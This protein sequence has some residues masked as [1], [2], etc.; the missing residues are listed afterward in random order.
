MFEKHIDLEV[1]QKDLEL[2]EAALETQ[3]KI[4]RVQAS[5][6]G[7]GARGRLNEI[8]RLLASIEAQRPG[9]RPCRSG[10]LSLPMLRW[11]TS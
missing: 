2:I 9:K 3:S 4:L 8:K 1:S 6:G 7:K 5:A 10:R 11:M